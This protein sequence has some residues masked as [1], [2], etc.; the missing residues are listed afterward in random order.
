MGL[1]IATTNSEK[2]FLKQQLK[3]D[4]DL[5]CLDPTTYIKANLIGLEYAHLVK[6]KIIKGYK[7]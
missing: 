2:K 7:D 1:F 3:K 5:I 4:Q 6:A